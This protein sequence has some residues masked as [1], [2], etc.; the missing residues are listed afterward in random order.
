MLLSA[1]PTAATV[2]H[3]STAQI[4]ANRSIMAAPVRRTAEAA[5]V[6][7][8]ALKEGRMLRFSQLTAAGLNRR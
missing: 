2:I 4:P 5:A 1:V 7:P 6:P 3:S 8:P